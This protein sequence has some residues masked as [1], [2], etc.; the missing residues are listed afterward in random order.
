VGKDAA[1]QKDT[2]LASKAFEVADKADAA[3]KV[4]PPPP[5]SLRTGTT[6]PDVVGTVYGDVLDTAVNTT[7]GGIGGST[8]SGG[9]MIAQSSLTATTT[10][11]TVIGG[12]ASSVSIVF[13]AIDLA[14]A[15]RGGVRSKRHEAAL[16][17]LQ[18]KTASDELKGALQY[19][20]D[21][22]AKKVERRVASGVL[23]GAAI[24]AGILG[25]VAIGVATLG[26][27]AV[28]AGVIVGSA[29]LGVV[30]W[31]IVHKRNKRAVEL[32]RMAS[33]LV[34]QATCGRPEDERSAQALISHYG[35]AP[36]GG[37]W[38]K[39]DKKALEAALRK[40][41][42]SR[43]GI[44]ATR[45]CDLLVNGKRSERFEA[46]QMLTALGLDP[47]DLENLLRT[48]QGE[49]ARKEVKD[50]LGTW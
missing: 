38:T 19:A 23:A 3:A 40:D 15:V 13:G 16:R 37:D 8:A 24:A 42:E 21:Q 32:A 22:K 4:Q 50:K 47:A 17:D 36:K 49:Q 7:V 45:L 27:G 48:G 9:Y 1:A 12:L 39:V 29:V 10:A 5:I 26:I 46:G 25:L 6:A 33:D 2:A 20:A 14:L 44:M 43:R 30:I 35:L 34:D 11:L 18:T 41:G 31:K 28:V